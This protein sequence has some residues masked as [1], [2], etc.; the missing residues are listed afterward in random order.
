[1]AMLTGEL[2]IATRD[3]ILI[4]AVDKARLS[5]RIVDEC[6]DRA[7]THVF[8]NEIAAKPSN[9]NKKRAEAG[10]ALLTDDEVA[11]MRAEGIEAGLAALYNDTWASGVRAARAVAANREDVLYDVYVRKAVRV[12]I[13][14]L[15]KT[16]KIAL[17]K[18]NKDTWL[19]ANGKMTMDDFVKRYLEHPTLGA[20]RDAQHREEA[21]L[22][23]EAE[24][25]IADL[26]KAAPVVTGTD[27]D[28][29]I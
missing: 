26:K 13:A 6:V 20:S 8:R 11:T 18:A 15:V 19:T 9:I 14:N 27:D 10:E 7:L 23:Y 2:K 21:R 25:K 1:M 24:K 5:D 4:A 3:G 22:Q 28:L 29:M 12:S 17:D 16:S